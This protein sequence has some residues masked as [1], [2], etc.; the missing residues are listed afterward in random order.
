MLMMRKK[1]EEGQALIELIVFLPLMFMVYSLVAGFASAING[2]INQQK[3]TRAYFYYRVQ[4]N[5]TLPAPS[6]G[7]HE[8]W[9][10]F[11]MF[12]IGW[13]ERLVGE[14]PIMTCYKISL[15][16]GQSD[17]KN[18][19]ESYE[20][21]SSQFIRIGTVYGVCGN[22]YLTQNGS[23][24]WL[25]NSLSDSANNYVQVTERDSCLIY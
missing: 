1:N 19:E 6:P 2:S 17:D 12:F 14:N 3:I 9:S 5:S 4:N 11:G 13:T 25:P 15:P 10:R 23:V 21:D 7:N 24:V 16:L 18:C 22:S 8:N 20:E